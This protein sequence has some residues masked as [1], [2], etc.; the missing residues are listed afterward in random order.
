ML[1]LKS[2]LGLVILYRLDVNCGVNESKGT[3]LI[4]TLKSLSVIIKHG[5]RFCSKSGKKCFPH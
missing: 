3:L 1:N 5:K 2:S 4:L